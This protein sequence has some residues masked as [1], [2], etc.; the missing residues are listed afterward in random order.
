MQQA[1]TEAE[2]TIPKAVEYGSNSML[3]LGQSM[4]RAMHRQVGDEEAMELACFFYMQGKMG[5]WLDAI[6]AGRRP[7][8]DTPF[9]IGVYAKMVQRIREAGAWPGHVAEKPVPGAMSVS[10]LSASIPP[11]SACQDTACLDVG[12]HNIGM[13]HHRY[14]TAPELAEGEDQP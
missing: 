13:T 14:P 4:A 5:R 7:G 6:V 3:D 8:D 10:S 1:E 12:K 11:I 2:R 9:D